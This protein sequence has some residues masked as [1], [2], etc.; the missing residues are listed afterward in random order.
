[1]VLKGIVVNLFELAELAV[2]KSVFD[3]VGEGQ[4]LECVL[5]G[6]VVVHLHVVVDG[7]LVRQ[8]EVVFLVVRCAQT[9]RGA[10]L[11]LGF[12]LPGQFTV[13]IHAAAEGGL[14]DW[15]CVFAG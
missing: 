13:G 2:C 5:V 11:L 6:R 14:L 7:L 3:V 10:V 8:V 1:M 12:F 4:V 15:L 9:V